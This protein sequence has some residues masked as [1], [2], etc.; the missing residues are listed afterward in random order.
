MSQNLHRKSKK[1]VSSLYFKGL[2]NCMSPP[3]SQFLGVG[4]KLKNFM[5]YNKCFPKATPN[6][7]FV[8]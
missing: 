8:I 7:C 6:D 2:N 1:H 4:V 5:S 3:N